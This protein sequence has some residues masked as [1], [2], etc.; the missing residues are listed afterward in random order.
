MDR[1]A[2]FEEVR[3]N[4]F[5][6]AYRMLGMRADAEDVV[7]DAY[8]RWLN[9]SDE[10]IRMPKPYLTTV[11]SRLSLDML[12]SAQRKREIYTGQWLPEPLVEPFG[13]ERLELAESLSMA[14]LHVLELLS[15][16]E[17]VAFL[18]REA[19]EA[20]YAELAAI[21]ET[22]EE[23]CRQI[24]ARARKHIR[25][26]RPRYVADPAKHMQVLREFVTACASGDPARLAG[27]LREDAVMYSDGGGKVL[28]APNPILGGDRIARFFA[29]VMKKAQFDALRAEILMV[30]GQP[31]VL[32]FAGNDV[33]SVMSLA[34]DE[35]NKVARIFLVV[36][37]EKLPGKTRPV[38]EG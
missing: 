21:L 27:L 13:S 18:L 36:N 34:L 16:T 9:A 1:T 20:S 28:A 7:Q 25:T 4:L 31:G 19:F 24:V 37:P 14:F 3:K 30:N 2:Q 33:Q 32:V 23:N 35:N 38:D 10:E 12:K 26:N 5:L 11:V 6:L 29:G 8:L 17:R 15:P 22:T